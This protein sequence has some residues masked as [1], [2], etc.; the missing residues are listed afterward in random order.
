MHRK[1]LFEKLELDA[2]RDFPTVEFLGNMGSVSLPIS[3]SLGSEQ[4][5]LAPGD[6]LALLGIGS[7]LVCLN[8]GVQ[9]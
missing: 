4:G 2:A 3:L 8:L 1:L 9:W 5:L 6:K 7:G